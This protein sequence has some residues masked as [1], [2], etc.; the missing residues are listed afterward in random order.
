MVAAMDR[1]SGASAAQASLGGFLLGA[2]PP[3]AARRAAL[4]DRASA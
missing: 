2:P 1:A 3:P 4:L